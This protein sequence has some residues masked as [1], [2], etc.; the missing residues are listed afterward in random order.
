MKYHYNRY[1]LSKA[2]W[3]IYVLHLQ[4]VPLDF[5]KQRKHNLHLSMGFTLTCP[6]HWIKSE[7]LSTDI[8]SLSHPQ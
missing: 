4:G 3:Q 6:P 7:A 8:L 5:G 2:S 1:Q